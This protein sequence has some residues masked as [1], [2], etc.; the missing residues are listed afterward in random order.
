MGEPQRTCAHVTKLV[1]KLSPTEE[2]V[3]V[4]R[5]CAPGPSPTPGR[6][7][8]LLSRN[9]AT[10]PLRSLVLPKLCICLMNSWGGS[11]FPTENYLYLALVHCTIKNLVYNKATANTSK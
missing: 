8:S 4:P 1:P 5:R 3:D 6:S 7:R 2:C 11:N 9:G 10:F